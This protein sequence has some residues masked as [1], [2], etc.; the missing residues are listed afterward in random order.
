[1]LGSIFHA[2]MSFFD[3]T[4][5]G[6]ILN[7]VSF[8]QSVVDLDITFRLGGFASIIQLIGIVAVM[9]EVTWQVLLLVV[10]MAVACLWMQV[11]YKESLPLVL[12]GVSCTF[13]GGQKIGIVVRTGSGKSTLIQALF[14]LVEP[15]TGSILIDNINISGIGLHDLQSHLRII[16]QDPAL[17]KGTIRG[18]LDPLEE[19]SDKE[20]WEWQLVSLGR[21]LLK[22]S[23]ILVVDEATTSVDTATDNLIQKIIREEF[24]DCTVCTIAH[25]I[26]SVIDSDLVL[27][28]NDG[29]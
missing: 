28:L 24:R 20:I 14:R 10:P 12:H 8:D 19:H 5:A 23:K 1:M 26:P 16:P 25:H 18:N 29:K 2:P 27:V 4:P 6:R 11:R 7:R 17:F 21:A 22:Q 15:S 9:L 3:S 13:P